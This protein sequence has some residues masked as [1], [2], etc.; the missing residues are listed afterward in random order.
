M[1]PWIKVD[2]VQHVYS[3][4]YDDDNSIEDGVQPLS[5]RFLS[6]RILAILLWHTILLLTYFV[7]LIFLRALSAEEIYRQIMV[8]SSMPPKGICSAVGINQSCAS[9]S[10]RHLLLT[11]R[12]VFS[13]ENV[14]LS[15]YQRY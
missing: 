6:M 12:F 15:Y 7:G 10:I 9:A 11:F 1:L 2:E 8:R 3:I 13:I 4:L 14:N 5:I